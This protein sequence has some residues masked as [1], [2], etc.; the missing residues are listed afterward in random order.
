MASKEKRVGLRPFSEI[1]SEMSQ[2]DVERELTAEMAK[3]ANACDET[4]KKGKLVITI[5]FAPGPKIMQVAVAVKSTIPKPALE[6][7]SFFMDD[8]GSLSVD[9]PRQTSMMPQLVKDPEN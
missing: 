9:N 6:S 3:V 5:D 8:K 2:G 4:K 7:T 1:L